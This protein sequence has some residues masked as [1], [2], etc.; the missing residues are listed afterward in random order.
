MTQIQYAFRE[1]AKTIAMLTQGSTVECPL[2]QIVTLRKREIAPEFLGHYMVMDVKGTNYPTS[3]LTEYG[4]SILYPDSHRKF[5]AVIDSQIEFTVK[6]R[7]MNK[8]TEFLPAYTGIGLYNFFEGQPYGY[9]V[10]LKVYAITEEISDSLMAKGRMGSAQ[11]I[12]L[13]DEYEEKTRIN[14]HEK[15]TPIIDEGTFEYIKYEI[16]H[17]LRLENALIGVYENDE[18]SKQLLQQKRDDYNDST[19]TYKHTFNEEDDVDRA[20]VDYEETY[21]RVLT[22][23]PELTE[24]I[25]YVRNIKAP[26]MVEWQTMFSRAADGDMQAKHR[27][28][29]MYIRN[30]VRIAL[31][32]SERFDLPVED[33]IQDGVLGLMTAI[34]K[35]DA[36]SNDTFQQYYPL[37][38]RQVIQRE[39][40]VYLYARYFPHHFHEKLLDIKEIGVKCGLSLPADYELIDDDFIEAVSN[41][42]E[43]STEAARKY[44]KYFVP[45]ISIDEY[46]SD[47]EQSADIRDTELIYDGAEEMF[48][49]A[50]QKEVRKALNEVLKTLTPREEHAIR[51]R[52]GFDDGRTRTL[53]EVGKVFNITRE[54]IRQ[55]ETKA[56][57]KLRHP[58]RANKFKNY[59]N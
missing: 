15:P 53:E 55:I 14:I 42:L 16:L 41:E 43:M 17:T 1:D 20:Q 48:I 54:R 58:S 8:L 30:V 44:L 28:A 34:E 9:L 47:H 25:D 45:E 49:Y 10:V 7:T 5:L 24:F 11:I 27:I 38:V 36:S 12:S 52:F 56:L 35:F 39:M 3:A 21:M 51:L 46:F 33:T 23:A 59:F 26:Q 29:E 13:Y 32:Y 2:C 22:L 50:Q 18:E 4:N 6:A 57:R 19:G 37:W 40:P 31:Y